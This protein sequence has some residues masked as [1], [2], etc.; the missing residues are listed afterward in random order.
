MRIKMTLFLL[1]TSFLALPTRGE[2]APATP[3][4]ATWQVKGDPD[5]ESEKLPLTG[6]LPN[7]W[8]RPDDAPS[9]YLDS[10][11]ALKEFW[12]A[13][14]AEGPPPEVDFDNYRLVVIELRALVVKIEDGSGGRR[15]LNFAIQPPVPKPKGRQC[16]LA[17]FPKEKLEALLPGVKKP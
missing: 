16:T 8:E 10:T 17:V 2:A 3:A 14:G 11:K 4:V 6:T 12:K 7:R 15:M 13:L 1:T 9:G 5:K